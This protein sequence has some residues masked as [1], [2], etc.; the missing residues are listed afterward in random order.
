MNTLSSLYTERTWEDLLANNMLKVTMCTVMLKN[1]TQNIATVLTPSILSGTI[2]AIAGFTVVA[3]P[4]IASYGH[5]S[6]VFQSLFAA[7]DLSTPTYHQITDKMAQNAAVSNA[8]LILFWAAVGL[9]VYMIAAEIVKSFGDG[10]NLIKELDYVNVKRSDIIRSEAQ[11]LLYRAGVLIAWLVYLRVFIKMLIPYAIAM[12]YAARLNG[13]VID[14]LQV[15]GALGLV[16]IGIHL[17][18]VFLRLLLLKTR[19]FNR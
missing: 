19:V 18:V 15:A 5:D 9:I 16:F 7:R 11:K 10:A 4:V 13:L 14:T 12:A 1:T 6:F 2:T 17:Q 3:V 8:P